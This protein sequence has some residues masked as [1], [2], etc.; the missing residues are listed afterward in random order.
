M[1]RKTNA[2]NQL[3]QDGTLGKQMNYKEIRNI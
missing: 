3:S 2:Y 1:V